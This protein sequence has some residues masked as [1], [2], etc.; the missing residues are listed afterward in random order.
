MTDADRTQRTGETRTE[1]GLLA[2]RY[3]GRGIYQDG[4]DILREPTGRDPM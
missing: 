2:L 3:G 1:R 4:R